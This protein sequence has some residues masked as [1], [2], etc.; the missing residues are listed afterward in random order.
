MEVENFR[1]LESGDGENTSTG[2]DGNGICMSGGGGGEDDE[3]VEE[4]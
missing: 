3:E 2:W 1:T 4:R